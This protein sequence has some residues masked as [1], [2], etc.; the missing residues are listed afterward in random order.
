MT[1]IE[2]KHPLAIRWFHW[3]NFPVL[4]LMIWSGMVIY[5]ANDV[6]RVGIGGFTLFRFFPAWFYDAFDL[7]GHLSQGMAW[8]FLFMWFF[9]LNGLLYVLYTAVS[10]EWRYLVPNRNSAREAI[11]VTLF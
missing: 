8:H 11:Q 9:A 10:G 1:K 5:W 2:H 3:I 4:S 7:G 6:C